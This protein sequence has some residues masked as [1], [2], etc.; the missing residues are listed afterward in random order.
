[1]RA[2]RCINR[3][4]LHCRRTLI[5]SFL[6]KF[7][8][9]VCSKLRQPLP[10]A[11]PLSY[12]RTISHGQ[13][14]TP[15]RPESQKVVGSS[16][17]HQAAYLQSTGE[18]VYIDDMPSYVNT[19]HAALVLSTQA[20]ARI[21]SIGNGRLSSI[22]LYHRSKPLSRYRGSIESTRFC[23]VRRSQRCSGFE[24]AE[25]SVGGRG[26]LCVVHRPV[27]RHCDWSGRG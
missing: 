25:G 23:L 22:G 21:K 4:V 2:K 8:S 26:T 6:F 19:L 7:Y 3:V 9:D 17:P 18:A 1:M 27:C 10:E 11:G 5:Q 12:D 14:I 16:L 15:D 24:P 20:H 13:Q